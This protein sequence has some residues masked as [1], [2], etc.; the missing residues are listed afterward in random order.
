[1]I[2][3]YYSVGSRLYVVIDVWMGTAGESAS[4]LLEDCEE[5]TFKWVKEEDMRGALRVH[6]D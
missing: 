4:M 6:P 3:T 2:G 1:M 5:E